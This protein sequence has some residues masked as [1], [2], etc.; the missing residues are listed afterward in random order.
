MS[1]STLIHL[2]LVFLLCSVF[3]AQAKNYYL[4]NSGNDQHSGN[5]IETAWKSLERASKQTFKPGDRLLMK[6]GEVFHGGLQFDSKDGGDGKKPFVIGSFGEGKAIID[7]GDGTAIDL[8]NAGGVAIEKLVV[9]GSGYPKNQ[10]DGIVF[11][12]AKDATAS[13]QAISV[14]H[15]EASGFAKRGQ[16]GNGIFISGLWHDVQIEDCQTHHNRFNGIFVHGAV[17]LNILRCR[18]WKNAGDPEYLENFSGN[19]IFVAG[20]KDVLIEHC[21]AWRNGYLCANKGGGPVGIWA[22]GTDKVL[23]QYCHSH[24]NGTNGTND[25]GGFDFDGGVT[26]GLMQYNYS[27]DNDGP[28]YL[29]Y[30]WGDTGVRDIIVRYNVTANDGAKNGTAG[31]LISSAV[32]DKPVNGCRIEHNTIIARPQGNTRPVAIRMDGHIKN[33]ELSNNIFITHGVPV[34]DATVKP[35]TVRFVSNKYVT[36]EGAE[37]KW[38]G[39]VYDTFE[40]WQKASGQELSVAPPA[41]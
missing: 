3:P 15:V 8:D 32:P 28:G 9:R 36:L 29:I 40:Q 10:G 2:A 24:H 23:I 13:T 34:M 20:S 6:G 4:A 27:H 17:R 18:A 5:T 12:N 31:F 41:P 30:E 1:F 14:R 38:N 22:A 35:D 37:F 21:E 7:A 25:G 16:N 11:R 26:N 33:I 19:G 39:T